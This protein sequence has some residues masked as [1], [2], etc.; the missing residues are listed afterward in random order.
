[1]DSSLDLL[2][3]GDAGYDAAT[4][5]WTASA[6]QKPALVARVRSYEGVV[7]AVRLASRSGLSVAVQSSGHGAAGVLDD[8]TLLVDTSD[9][10][11]VSVDRAARTAVVGAGTTWGDVAAVTGSLAVARSASVGLNVHRL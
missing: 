7:D 5:P 2:R 8:S 1:M 9:L 4:S 3:P 11:S 6:V 10:V